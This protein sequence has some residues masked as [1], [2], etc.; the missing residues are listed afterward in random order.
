M[1]PVSGPCRRLRRACDPRA[2]ERRR[3]DP[4]A[5]REERNLF[6]PEKFLHDDFGAGLAER[7]V[8]K[9]IERVFSLGE[10]H[11]DDDALAR[12]QSI[13]LDDDWR[14]LAANVI[15]GRAS[16]AK[17]P[18]IARRHP[19]LAAEIL[20]EP[21]G[22]FELGRRPARPETGDP[23]RLEIVGYA[24]HQRRFGPTTTRSTALSRQKPTTAA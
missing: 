23:G 9:S 10:R 17:A 3:A 19:E 12:R 14:A 4:V 20:R 13:R 24:R 16:V 11:R 22:P 8:E 2:A 5:E 21:V 15:Q 18:V 1:P 6:A 7:P